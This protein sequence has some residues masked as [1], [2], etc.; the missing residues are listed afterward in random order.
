MGLMEDDRPARSQTRWPI[1]R[2]RQAKKI[3]GDIKLK[4]KPE[5]WGSRHLE[6]DCAGSK[7]V[8]AGNWL[9]RRSICTVQL[10]PRAR[11]VLAC[12]SASI[13][14][15]TIKNISSGVP[16]PPAIS[17]SRISITCMASITSAISGDQN[18]IEKLQNRKREDRLV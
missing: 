13:F 1:D 18:N 16:F 7:F 9:G 4:K 6:H 12:V 8:G 10:P 2:C 5:A 15:F 11:M 17:R 3:P 14:S